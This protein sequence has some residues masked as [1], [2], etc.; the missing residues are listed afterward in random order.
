MKEQATD[1]L[2]RLQRLNKQQ[3]LDRLKEMD[4]TL[5]EHLVALLFE[6]RGYKAETVGKS[7]DEGV[8]VRLQKGK[9]SAVAQCKRYADSVGQPTVRDLYGTMLHNTAD[10][11]SRRAIHDRYLWP[12][13]FDKR[14][15]HTATSQGGHQMFNCRNRCS[16]LIAQARIQWGHFDHVPQC[17]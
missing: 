13:E 8:D 9:I 3:I 15:V 17:R 11:R 14:V 12:V 7:G 1:L 5:F 16:S 2:T 6:L 4:P 10:E